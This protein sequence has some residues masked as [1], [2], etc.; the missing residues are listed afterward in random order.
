MNIQMQREAMEADDRMW[1]E[2]IRDV[3]P[4]DRAFMPYSRWLAWKLSNRVSLSRLFNWL[5]AKFD[6]LAR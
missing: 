1:S 3:D 4:D 2:Y 6:N 5:L